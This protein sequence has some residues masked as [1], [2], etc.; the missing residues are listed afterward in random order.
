MK[1]FSTILIIALVSAIGELIF[2]WWIIGL[3]TLSAGLLAGLKPGKAFLSGFLAISLFWLVAALFRDIPNDHILSQ[4]M[5]I[6]FFK[7]PSFPLFL[8]VIAIIGGLVGGLCSLT[9]AYIRSLSK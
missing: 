4:R 9:G 1:F 3:V 6:L 8:I 5:A 2:P 7:K